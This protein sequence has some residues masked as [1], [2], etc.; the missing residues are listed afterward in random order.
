[1]LVGD[2]APEIFRAQR[3]ER[4]QHYGDDGCPK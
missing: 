3:D 4:D 2:D 1:V